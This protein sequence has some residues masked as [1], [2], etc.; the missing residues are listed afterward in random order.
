MRFG[1]DVKAALDRPANCG[2]DAL[3]ISE[4][5]GRASVSEAQQLPNR[6]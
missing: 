1:T 6:L 4:R 5:Y 2:T 3:G